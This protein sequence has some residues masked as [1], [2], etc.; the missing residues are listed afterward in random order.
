MSDHLPSG[1]IIVTSINKQVL[2]FRKKSCHIH[3]IVILS[4]MILNT[5]KNLTALL[6]DSNAKLARSMDILLLNASVNKCRPM[7]II[8]VLR[9]CSKLGSSP[10]S[11]ITLS[12]S[13]LKMV[14]LI[15][16]HISPFTSLM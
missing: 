9:K 13:F 8:L 15:A 5:T 16:A 7:F 2:N 3:L 12:M 10:T 4:V 14:T 1:S 6:E 11:L